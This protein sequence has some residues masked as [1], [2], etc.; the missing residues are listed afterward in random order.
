M[1][2][3]TIM[4]STNTPPQCGAAYGGNCPESKAPAMSRPIPV[5][6]AE[7]R[8]FWQAGFRGELV[9]PHCPHCSRY[10]F[11]P[12]PRCQ[13]CLSPQL[14]W[15]RVSGYGRLRSW[16]DVYL[17]AISGLSAPFT[18]AE[19]EL[20]EQKDLVLVAL[21]RASAATDLSVDQDVQVV[22]GDDVDGCRFPEV[23]PAGTNPGVG[24]IAANDAVAGGNL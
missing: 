9:L 24:P 16:T 11:P 2:G 21:V 6:T 19:V 3:W 18:I 12:P 13:V 5:P 22:F 7:T 1:N 17:D 20:S 23:I 4:R 14:Q 15:E 8:R 10:F